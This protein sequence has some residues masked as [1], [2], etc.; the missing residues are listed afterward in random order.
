MY[1]DD[2]LIEIRPDMNV[3]TL[4]GGG[5]INLFRDNSKDSSGSFN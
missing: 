1:D 4:G 5:D 3:N 2:E